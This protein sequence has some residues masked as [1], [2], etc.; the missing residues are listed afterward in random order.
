MSMSRPIMSASIALS[1]HRDGITHR[2]NLQQA[3]CNKMCHYLFR[4]A[5]ADVGTQM[6]CLPRSTW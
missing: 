2:E 5:I 3:F 4:E 1:R 6:A